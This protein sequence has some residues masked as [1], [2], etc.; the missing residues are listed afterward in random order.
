MFFVDCEVHQAIALMAKATTIKVLVVR[1]KR[2]PIQ[3][4]Q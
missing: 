1:E 3:S 2:R 4:V